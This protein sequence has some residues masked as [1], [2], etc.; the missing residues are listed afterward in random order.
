MMLLDTEVQKKQIGMIADSM[1]EWE[2]RIAEE[3]E[4]SQPD[5]ACIKE[6]YKKELN[7]QM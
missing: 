2:G 3:L 4:L 6:K 5:I 7:L 1:S